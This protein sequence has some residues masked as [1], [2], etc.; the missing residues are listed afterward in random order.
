MAY[1]SYTH[2]ICSAKAGSGLQQNLLLAHH[3]HLC[4]LSP[5][6]PSKP[7][8][9][10]QKIILHYVPFTQCVKRQLSRRA[11]A[12]LCRAHLEYEPQKC[13]RNPGAFGFCKVNSGTWFEAALFRAN[14]LAAAARGHAAKC[15]VAGLV[16]VSAGMGGWFKR[17]SGEGTGVHID[18][19]V[20]LRVISSVGWQR[21]YNVI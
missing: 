10:D 11:F 15:A 12:Q 8:D 13:P 3:T 9:G 5:W 4:I 1:W 21:S 20:N 16:W 14:Q 7:A 2:H 6:D 18:W 19:R 17:A